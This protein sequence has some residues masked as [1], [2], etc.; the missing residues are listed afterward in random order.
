MRHTSILGHLT[1]SRTSPLRATGLREGLQGSSWFFYLASGLL[2]GCVV[3]GGSTRPGFISDTILQLLAIPLLLWCLWKLLEVPL[4]KQTLLVLLFSLAVAALPVLQ[5]IPLPPL[6]WGKLPSRDSSAAAYEIIGADLPWMPISVSPEATW[7]SALALIPPL[8]IF[9]ATLLLPYPAR[10]RLTLVVL[11]VGVVSVFIGL[12][13]VAQGAESPLRFYQFTSA[14]EP[15]GFFANRNHFAALIYCLVLFAAAW[16]GHTALLAGGTLRRRAYAEPI[17]AAIGSFVL[18]LVLLACEAMTGSRVGLVLTM[19]ALVG[20]LALGFSDRRAGVLQHSDEQRASGITRNKLLLSAVALALV[21]VVQYTLYGILEK[22]GVDPLQDA[23]V[24]FVH[25]TVEAAAAYM[26]F[27]SGLGTFVPVYAS[28]EKPQDTLANAYAN[29]AH[30]DIAELWLESGLIGLALMGA[31]ALWFLL[32]SLQIWRSL[33]EGARDIDWSLSRAATLV[34]ALIVAHSFLDY[35]LRTGAMSAIFAFA[36]ALMIEPVI[37]TDAPVQPAQKQARVKRPSRKARSSRQRTQL[38]IP[39][40]IEAKSA[41]P[42]KPWGS[43][44]E[45]PEAWSSKSSRNSNTPP[46]SEPSDK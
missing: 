37:S 46:R 42:Q 15:V 5:L 26:P 18:I 7:L 23:R 36:C 44:I 1:R 4:S 39:E 21:F 35:P 38:P 12:I 10:R 25:R 45:W 40:P 16:A 29:H 24:R 3:L 34:V 20:A 30:N 6:I 14:T 41:A 43:D 33:P 17:I 9:L 11:A 28:F 2:V 19:V 32:R 13:Q 8:A 22:F 27:G 31:F